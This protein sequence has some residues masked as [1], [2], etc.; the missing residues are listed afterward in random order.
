MRQSMLKHTTMLEETH[1]ILLN[2]KKCKI[3]NVQNRYFKDFCLEWLSIKK[4]T[5]SSRQIPSI[6]FN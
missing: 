4:I 2:Q 5:L 1:I 6:I 3:E